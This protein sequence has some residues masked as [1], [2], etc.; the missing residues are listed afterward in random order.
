[1]NHVYVID[2]S[3]AIK[4]LLD[5]EFSDRAQALVEESRRTR[6]PLFAPP[7]MA[8]EVTN[9]IFQ[10]FRR[11]G[12]TEEEADQAISSYFTQSPVQLLAPEG[13]YQRAFE[14]ARSNQLSSTYD[15][16]FVVLA[17]MLDAELWTDDRRLLNSVGGIAPWVRSIGDY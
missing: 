2:A 5:E 16:V 8:S 1:M 4:W 9:A 17:E 3:V 10:R 15:S 7:H 6:R 13:I 11:R 14:F 12:I